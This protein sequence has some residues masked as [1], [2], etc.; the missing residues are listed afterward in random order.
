MSPKEGKRYGKISYDC[1]IK[2]NISFI[3]GKDGG[4]DLTVFFS[5]LVNPQEGSYCASITK[6]TLEDWMNKNAL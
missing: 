4:G 2:F 6:G 3:G 1:A 5:P